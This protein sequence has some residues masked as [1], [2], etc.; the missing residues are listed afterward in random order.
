L[1]CWRHN[2]NSPKGVF[3]DFLGSVARMVKRKHGFYISRR[4]ETDKLH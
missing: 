3:A 1:G 2:S 4:G